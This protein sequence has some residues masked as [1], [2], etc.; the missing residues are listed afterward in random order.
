VTG[1]AFCPLLH[2]SALDER[3]AEGV[4][5]PEIDS[6][7]AGL[8]A[9]ERGLAERLVEPRRRC[10]ITQQLTHTAK[11]AE[12]GLAMAELVHDLRQPLTA[13][14]GFAQLL[15]DH[16]ADAEAPA[17]VAEIRRQSTRLEQM[18]ERLR[19]FVRPSDE[20]REARADVSAAARE[21]V[22]LFY[23]LPPGVALD[24]EI[25][26]GDLPKVGAEPGALVQVLFNL[27]ANARDAL[28]ERE[29]GRILVRVEATGTGVRAWVADNGTGILPEIR[30]RLFEPFATSKGAAGTGLG[31]YICRELV[32]SW[33]GTI[34]LVEPTRAPYRTAFAVDL[35]AVQPLPSAQPRPAQVAP[36]TM[37]GSLSTSRD[38]AGS[39]LQARAGR[40]IQA[41][42]PQTQC[43]DQG[44]V[45]P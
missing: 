24:L 28:G 20:P 42:P 27:L 21:A 9:P 1:A 43:L 3:C 11:L 29:H 17:W 39:Q 4:D 16:P 36:R 2:L 22:S 6:A 32:A 44:G 15:H 34:G 23:S 26:Q 25:A 41:L 19:C 31:L 18:I 13:I 33:G 45:L 8:D 7:P 35:P 5:M 40:P 38:A 30:S 12:V 14:S 10:N 37:A